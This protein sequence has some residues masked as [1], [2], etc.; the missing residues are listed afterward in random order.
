MAM[1]TLGWFHLIASTVLMICQLCDVRRGSF[2]PLSEEN[3][4][5]KRKVLAVVVD[6]ASSAFSS[7]RI[8]VFLLIQLLVILVNR[9]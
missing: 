5:V 2:G 3:G 9:F 4:V 7:E 1:G 6:N 8:A